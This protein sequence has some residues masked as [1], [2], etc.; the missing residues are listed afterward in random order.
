M[1]KHL[2]RL[3]FVAPLMALTAVA[4]PA[5]RPVG[6]PEAYVITPFGYFHPSCV[7]YVAD[8][9]ELLADGRIRH[10]NGTEDA[11]APVCQYPRYSAQGALIA[12]DNTSELTPVTNGW[13]E[14]V[15]TVAP[16]SYGKLVATWKTPP[17]P[18]VNSGQTLFFFPGFEDITN[19]QSIVQP[20]LQWGP[21]AAGGGSFWALS[22]WNCCLSGIADFS[23]LISVS[24]G[25]PILGAITPTCTPGLNCA[26]WNVVSEDRNTGARTVLRKTPSKGQTWNWAFGAVAEVYSVI[27]CANYPNNNGVTFNVRLYDQN[28]ALIASPAWTKNAATGVTP[29]CGFGLNSTATQETVRYQP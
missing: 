4:Q 2:A 19:V 29:N 12:A 18:T 20:V 10:V 16:S 23:P 26:T 13:V 9:E 21:S 6:V 8:G 17:A 22:S 7:R 1:K 5:A 3:V 11:A 27:Q 14:S 28:L 25:D 24:T 15:S